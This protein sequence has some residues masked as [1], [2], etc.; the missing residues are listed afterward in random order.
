MRIKNQ[1]FSTQSQTRT[2]Q[3]TF[4]PKE[5]TKMNQEDFFEP[6]KQRKKDP[7]MIFVTT[8]HPK[9]NQ[10]P[11]VLQSDFHRLQNSE[12]SDLLTEKPTVA[13]K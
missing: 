3:E 7:S 9:L 1:Y 8:W 12:F 5:I 2:P 10:L 13:F 4:K 6:V 11:T